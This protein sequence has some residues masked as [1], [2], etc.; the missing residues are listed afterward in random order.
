MPKAGHV[1]SEAT[2][3]SSATRRHTKAP[4]R[5]RPAHRSGDPPRPPC[6]PA[7]RWKRE[8]AAGEPERLEHRELVP[9]SPHRGHQ[10]EADR[11]QRDHGHEDRERSGSSSIWR[12]RSISAGTA[13]ETSPPLPSGGATSPHGDAVRAARADDEVPASVRAGA[14]SARWPVKTAPSASGSGVGHTGERGFDRRC[15]SGG[16]R[17]HRRHAHGHRPPCGLPRACRRRARP[18]RRYAEPDRPMIAGPSAAGPARTLTRSPVGPR[19]PRCRC[20]PK[21]RR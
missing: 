4:E 21:P 5:G 3:S 11:H 19:L 2:P 20:T 8:L 17:R 12:T 18:R 7:T 9:A 6:S 1:G 16:C 15:A 13:N 10:R 14:S